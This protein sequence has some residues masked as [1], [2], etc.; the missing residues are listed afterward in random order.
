MYTV[1]NYDAVYMLFYKFSTNLKHRALVNKQP[2]ATLYTR[3]LFDVHMHI[4][5]EIK[6]LLTEKQTNKFYF[7]VAVFR[8]IPSHLL[9]P[10][11][12]VKPIYHALNKQFK[13]SHSG[14]SRTLR[15]ASFHRVEHFNL[16]F[17]YI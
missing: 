8:V 3:F 7:N 11:E 5:S 10:R 12:N 2:F 16:V 1:S 13:P 4:D 9:N 15:N 6:L 14:G 17:K